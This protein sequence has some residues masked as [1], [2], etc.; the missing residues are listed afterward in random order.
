[1]YEEALKV[2]PNADDMI[3]ATAVNSG[4]SYTRAVLKET[5]RMNP[6]SV[7]IG[8]ILNK[9]MVLGGYH[10]PKNVSWINWNNMLKALWLYSQT[11][12]VTQ[13]FVSCRLEKNFTK[14]LEF[15]PERWIKNEG[16]KSSVNPFLVIPFGHG[17]RSC[18]ARRFA[19]QNILVFL[20]RVS[21]IIDAINFDVKILNSFSYLE[22]TS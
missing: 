10:V 2:L 12:V 14:P 5:L 18:I 13:N 19:E 7:G 9:D 15:I 22:T 6:I 20:L 11:I 3:S 4:M 16:V 8:R 21:W 1:M 17:S